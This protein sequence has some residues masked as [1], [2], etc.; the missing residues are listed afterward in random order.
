MP[1]PND[2]M[3]ET[4]MLALCARA[5]AKFDKGPRGLDRI[6]HREIE[7]LVLYVVCTGGL[8]A[9]RQALTAFQAVQHAVAE[10]EGAA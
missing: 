4:E 5:A 6:I 2:P 1:H 9:C 3:S 7:A 10:E 8:P